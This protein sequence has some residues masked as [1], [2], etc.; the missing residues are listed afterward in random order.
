MVMKSSLSIAGPKGVNRL[1]ELGL[2]P[3]SVPRAA[4]RPERF[5][6]LFRHLTHTPNLVPQGVQLLALGNCLSPAP[7]AEQVSDRSAI[8]VVDLDPALGLGEPLPSPATTRVA[9]AVD[10][11][12]GSVPFLLVHIVQEFC[13]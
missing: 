11:L 7:G 4:R 12:P 6:G 8:L 2:Q 9:L 1:A 5:D 3:V 13:G 10:G